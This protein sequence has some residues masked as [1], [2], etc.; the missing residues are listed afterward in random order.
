MLNTYYSAERSAA[1]DS[2]AGRAAPPAARDDLD[3]IAIMLAGFT[4]RSR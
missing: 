4:G 2:S 3:A 1:R